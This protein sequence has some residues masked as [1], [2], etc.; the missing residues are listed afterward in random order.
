MDTYAEFRVAYPFIAAAVETSKLSEDELLSFLRGAMQALHCVK[1]PGLAL[2]NRV[3]IIAD[4]GQ[5]WFRR[6]KK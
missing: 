5:N 2:D 3:S 1:Q 6:I 4:F